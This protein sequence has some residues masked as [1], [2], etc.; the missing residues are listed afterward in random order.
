MRTA[1][2]GVVAALAV[3]A[4]A[5]VSMA[6]AI[7]AT[8]AVVPATVYNIDVTKTVKGYT[9]HVFG[10]VDVDKQAKTVSGHIEVTVTDPSGTV[11]FDKTYDFSFTWSS[12]PAPITLALPGIGVVTISFSAMGGIAVT[13]APVLVPAQLAA[14]HQRLD[15]VQ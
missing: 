3:L 9:I 8:D 7:S 10:W 4:L 14:W 13:A 12:T 11:I 15:R 5:A 6:P 2:L 1:S